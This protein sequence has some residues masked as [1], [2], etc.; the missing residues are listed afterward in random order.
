[1]G[2]SMKGPNMNISYGGESNKQQKSN[3]MKDNPVAKHASAMN[4]GKAHSKSPNYKYSDT[5]MELTAEGKKKILASDANPE[6]KKAIAKS[7]V[8]PGSPA[9]LIDP[10]KSKKSK[11]DT[12]R[13]GGKKPILTDAQKKKRKENL[14]NADKSVP[15]RSPA[16]M[17]GKAKGGD[18]GIYK[19]GCFSGG[20]KYKK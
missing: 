20:K 6:F 3:L 19:K 12:Y 17:K 13:E 14:E 15:R 1:M 11:K 4:M 8:K 9:T 5:P 18:S 10:K 7:P 2:F 16:T